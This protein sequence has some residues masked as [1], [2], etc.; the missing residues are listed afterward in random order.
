M[1]S[2]GGVFIAYAT[3]AGSVAMEGAGPHSPFTQALLRNITKPISIDD[4]FSLVTREVRLVTK[5]TQRPYKY[6]SLENIV[7]LTGSCSTAPSAVDADVFQQAKHSETDD[8]QIALQTQNPEAL[9]AYLEKYPDSPKRAEVLNDISKLRRSEFNEWTL[10]AIPTN[11]FPIYLEISSIRQIGDRAA[12]RVKT[13]VDP[14]SPTGQQYR[15]AAYGD[16]TYVHDCTKPIFA[17]SETS[18]VSKSGQTLYHY[19]WGDP[20]YLNLAMGTPVKPGTVAYDLRN[21]ICHD[22]GRT[23]LVG[24]KE[25]AAKKFLS[26]SST[27][28]GDGDIFYEPTQNGMNSVNQ[29]EVTLVFRLHADTA[30]S[31]PAVNSVPDLPKY[32]TELDRLLLKCDERK[33]SIRKSEYYNAAN[34]LINLFVADFSKEIAWNDFG[35]VSPYVMLQRIVCKPNEVQK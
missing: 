1:S 24:K 31:F 12:V 30:L 34:D 7:C 26:L 3:D 32:R 22:L 35:D 23:P 13:I 20:E 9:E 14:A 5:N 19:K 27:V 29:K 10:Y 11:N 4:M 33:F 6:A 28:T 25:L 2:G 21:I 18:I 17:T 15:D 16:D 8:L